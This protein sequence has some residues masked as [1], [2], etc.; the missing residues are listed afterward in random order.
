MT[1]KRHE[2]KTP[3]ALDRMLY[4]RAHLSGGGW[5]L[6]RQ[7]LLDIIEEDIITK[8]H[9]S[10]NSWAVS[11]LT[12]AITLEV[13]SK[14]KNVDDYKNKIHYSPNRVIKLMAWCAKKAK[15]GAQD[16]IERGINPQAEI[17]INPHLQRARK[18]L[19]LWRAR[20]ETGEPQKREREKRTA[21]TH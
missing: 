1:D 12:C 17:T 20:L 5:D 21:P 15:E 11:C 13:F 2:I 9:H 14:C 4:R 6:R 3:E 16:Y 18:A 10:P 7:R 8:R 19:A